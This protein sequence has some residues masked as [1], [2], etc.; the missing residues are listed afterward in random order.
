MSK[1]KV[2]ESVSD[3]VS[4]WQGHLLSCCGQLKRRILK[5][6]IYLLQLV[7]LFRQEPPPPQQR[8]CS[9]CPTCPRIWSWSQ[10]YWWWWLYL[11]S[12][13]H[14]WNCLSDLSLTH[15]LP[16]WCAIQHL[17]RSRP[18]GRVKSN[19]ATETGFW[20]WPK[21]VGGLK[22]TGESWITFR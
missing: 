1:V 5:F 20:L 10:L 6:K 8:S 3:S 18:V 4:E 17:P 2:S 7:G 19:R 11:Y 15:L 16:S 14:I 22:Y 13:M 21:Q 9:S 12:P